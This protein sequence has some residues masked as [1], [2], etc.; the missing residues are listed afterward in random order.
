MVS[1]IEAH[2]EYVSFR[3]LGLDEI[4]KIVDG[5]KLRQS[6]VLEGFVFNKCFH[7]GDFAAFDRYGA[8][9]SDGLA[10]TDSLELVGVVGDPRFLPFRSHCRSVL[11][12]LYS[13]A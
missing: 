8:A 10:K 9:Q 2:N 7:G 6:R 3:L 13:D 5:F 4:E 12:F 11:R 1:G